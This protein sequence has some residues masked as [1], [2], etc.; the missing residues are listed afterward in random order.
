MKQYIKSV[1]VD[2]SNESNEDKLNI[3]SDPNTNPEVLRVLSEDSNKYI[4]RKVLANPSTPVEVLI[5]YL[6]S[7]KILDLEAIA[8]N[9][10]ITPAII[11]E[12]A[13][14]DSFTLNANLV[15]NPSTP[16]DILDKIIFGHPDNTLLLQWAIKNPNASERIQNA[17]K[18]Y[19]SAIDVTKQQ[20]A[21]YLER[22][23]RNKVATVI[24]DLDNDDFQLKTLEQKFPKYNAEWCTGD[25]SEKA[26]QA[27]EDA[28]AKLVEYELTTLFEGVS[29]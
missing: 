7:A 1:T 21:E 20:I 16:S 9:P 22:H 28:I 14:Y 13:K 24:E 17:Y 23:L 15:G 27:Y 2:I 25:I 5:H 3:A 29:E 18:E 11:N 8:T 6:V 10:S 19:I 26:A 4:V 12:L